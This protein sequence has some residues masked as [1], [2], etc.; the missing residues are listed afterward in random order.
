MGMKVRI[1]SV[2]LQQITADANASP[3]AEICGLLF[4]DGDMVEVAEP[5][6][7]V[8]S[9]PSTTFE[10]DPSRLIAAH[11]AMRAG[12]PKLIGCY[13]SHPKGP[14]EPSPRDAAAADADGWLWI[15]AAA[16][17]TR[18][19]RAVAGGSLHGMFEPLACEIVPP[20]CADRA[21]SPEGAAVEHVRGEVSR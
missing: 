13:H 1:S 3:D 19:Y 16:S 20:G 2:A 12:G 18:I 6:S 7:N 14:P 10:I 5:C 8:A 11:R 17:V 9:D 21:P 15:I 4:G